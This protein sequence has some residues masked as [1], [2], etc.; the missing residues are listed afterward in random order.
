MVNNDSDDSNDSEKQMI[1]DRLKGIRELY[2]FDIDDYENE[3][4]FH[5]QYCMFSDRIASSKKFMTY[6]FENI[7]ERFLNQSGNLRKLYGMFVLGEDVDEI[8]VDENINGKIAKFQKYFYKTKTKELSMNIFQDVT[9]LYEK[10][11][12]EYK[13]MGRIIKE[14]LDILN[15]ELKNAVETNLH[16][17]EG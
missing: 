16:T 5:L 15:P 1:I 3:L 14:I 11:A 6:V 9:D 8:K 13:E 4:R 12:V 2:Q 7:I 10:V 17:G